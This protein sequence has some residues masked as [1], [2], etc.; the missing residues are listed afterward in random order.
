MKLGAGPNHFISFADTS[1]TANVSLSAAS[2]VLST[3]QD[4]RGRYLCSGSEKWGGLSALETW[5]SELFQNN[6][7]LKVLQENHM[8]QFFIKYLIFPMS[9]AHWNLRW[10]SSYTKHC[11]FCFSLL[12]YYQHFDGTFDRYEPCEP[13]LSCGGEM[14]S[15]R[16][17]RRWVGYNWNFNCNY[18]T[19]KLPGK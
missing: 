2:K 12:G 15:E 16:K 13:V 18:G 10:N 8:A 7:C 1:I 17:L 6:N 14:R 4:P 19:F 11:Y 5:T 3:I 9:Q